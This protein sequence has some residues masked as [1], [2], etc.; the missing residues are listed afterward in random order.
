[1]VAKPEKKTSMPFAGNRT[2]CSEEVV[3]RKGRQEA[4]SN[5]RR[6]FE[7]A[8]L[9]IILGWLYSFVK[10]RN[11]LAKLGADSAN[12]KIAESGHPPQD[13]RRTMLAPSVALGQERQD[14]VTLLHRLR[15]AAE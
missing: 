3:D 9:E 12:Q 10:V 8:G 14:A 2:D 13:Q 11:L 15:S 4:Q 5:Q 7:S 1:M 6:G